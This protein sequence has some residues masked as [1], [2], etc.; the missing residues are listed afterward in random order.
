M[1]R[2]PTQI[3]LSLSQGDRKAASDLLPLLYD[4][5]HALAVRSLGRER[6]DHTLQP[7]ALINEVY[8]RLVDQTRVDW[9]GKAHFCAV[10]A[11]MMRRVLV[12][13]ARHHAAEKRGGQ[14]RQRV[15]GD[16]PLDHLLTAPDSSSPVDVI[17]LDD[18]ME[19]LGKLNSRQAQ[20]AELRCFGGL[21]IAETASVL[22]VSQATVKNDW[23]FARAWLA[24]Q[25]KPE[26]E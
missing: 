2:D 10:A 1:T 25:L 11:T 12:D 15:M 21:T 3:T 24:S 9:Q 20:I 22:G 8:L 26:D 6:P 7:T 14:N 16:L 4:E 23:R 17:M 5:L 18:L 19:Q 13:H